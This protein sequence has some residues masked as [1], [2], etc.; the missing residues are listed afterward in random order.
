M[1]DSSNERNRCCDESY[2]EQRDDD[3]FVMWLSEVEQ[4][5]E[6]EEVNVVQ[7]HQEREAPEN[8]E[9]ADARKDPLS[10]DLHL[11]CSEA[12]LT[13]EPSGRIG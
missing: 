3:V 9:E 8:G 12:S 5:R 10:P 4:I 11:E 1:E 13:L 7:R 2:E 6:R